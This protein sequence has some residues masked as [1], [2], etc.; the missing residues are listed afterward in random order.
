MCPSTPETWKVDSISGR[1][2]YRVH[3]HSVTN[4]FVTNTVV[5]LFRG[6]VYNM[7]SF[8]EG[9]IVSTI[10]MQCL[11]FITVPKGKFWNFLSSF[12]KLHNIHDICFILK[13]EAFFC[14]YRSQ[15]NKSENTRISSTNAFQRNASNKNISFLTSKVNNLANFKVIHKKINTRRWRTRRKQTVR[16]T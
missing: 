8:L 2:K 10:S 6:Q 12:T 7:G 5:E 13:W 4:T 3:K 16:K 1:H 11:L 9:L 15:K 14:Q